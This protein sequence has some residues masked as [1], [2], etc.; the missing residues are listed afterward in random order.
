MILDGILEVDDDGDPQPWLS[1][2][3]LIFS[4]DII[5]SFSVAE[6][7]EVEGEAA[8]EDVDEVEVEEDGD[9]GDDEE[10]G[11]E[12]EEDDGAV[13]AGVPETPPPRRGAQAEPSW[14]SKFCW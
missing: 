12:E 1:R 13:A 10:E 5:L 8:A 11:E 6:T 2:R 7:D 9:G 3:F 4:S 14:S